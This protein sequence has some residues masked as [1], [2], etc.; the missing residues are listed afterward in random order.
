MNLHVYCRKEKLIYRMFVWK[1]WPVSYISQKVL[2]QDIKSGLI[3]LAWIV[4]PGAEEQNNKRQHKTK[5]NIFF[6]NFS[7]LKW[8]LKWHDYERTPFLLPSIPS[9]ASHSCQI[10]WVVYKKHSQQYLSFFHRVTQHGIK[11]LPPPIYSLL[12][13]TGARSVLWVCLSMEETHISSFVSYKV[14]ISQCH[15]TSAP[16]G[17]QML[18]A[19]GKQEYVLITI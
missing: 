17:V 8:F 2:V 12:P 15:A 4:G 6:S 5:I 13:E 18:P 1:H 19:E 3:V 9:M 7:G 14:I 16:A 11:T 10:P